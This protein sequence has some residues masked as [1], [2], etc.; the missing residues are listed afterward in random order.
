MV[1]ETSDF[2]LG[3]TITDDLGACTDMVLGTA[4]ND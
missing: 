4:E 2:V 1:V 3:E